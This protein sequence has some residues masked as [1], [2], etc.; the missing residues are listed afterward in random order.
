MIRATKH[1]EQMPHAR[2]I[3]TPCVGPSGSR[4]PESRRAYEDT[5]L[6][7]VLSL[8]YTQVCVC[9]Y[10][11]LSIYIYIYIYILYVYPTYTHIH[12]YTPIYIYIYI[13]AL[14]IY[15]Y[16]Y[17]YIHIY[18]MYICIYIHIYI[19]IYVYLCL[20]YIGPMSRAAYLRVAAI[21][22]CWRAARRLPF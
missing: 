13:Y 6:Y 5:C 15:I 21:G 10:I 17:V 9:I 19:Y 8:V 3:S 22:V 11:C 12:I 20:V 18:E 1:Y 4:S 2:I 14:Y 16:I 7:Y